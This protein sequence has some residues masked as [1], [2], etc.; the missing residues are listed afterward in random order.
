MN[1][2]CPMIEIGCIECTKDFP[3]IIENTIAPEL[4]TMMTQVKESC[5]VVIYNKYSP[6]EQTIK[7]LLLPKDLMR[8]SIE[9]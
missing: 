1:F 5:A 6:R 9:K 2:E 3:E 4:S 7:V 8:A